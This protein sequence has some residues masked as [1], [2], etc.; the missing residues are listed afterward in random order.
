MISHG[1]NTEVTGLL[2]NL[3]DL[4]AGE[5]VNDAGRKVAYDAACVATVLPLGDSQGRATKYKLQPKI[6]AQAKAATED[7]HWG[8]MVAL[9]VEQSTVTD[10]TVLDDLFKDIFK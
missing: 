5:F 1:L 3:Y 4:E 9:R 8:C 7:V 10:L 2:L 6:V